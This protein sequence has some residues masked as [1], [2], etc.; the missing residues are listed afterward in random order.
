MLAL[1]QSSCKHSRMHSRIFYGGICAPSLQMT[2]KRYMRLKEEPEKG[3]VNNLG[4]S[5]KRG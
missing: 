3:N 4:Y 5:F 2:W 1:T